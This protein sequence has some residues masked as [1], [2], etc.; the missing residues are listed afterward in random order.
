MSIARDMT[1]SDGKPVRSATYSAEFL[2]AN[3]DLRVAPFTG[4]V[5]LPPTLAPVR[6]LPSDDRASTLELKRCHSAVRTMPSA[7]AL[8]SA[9]A[10]V[11][12]TMPLR[13]AVPMPLVTGLTMFLLMMFLLSLLGLV[14]FRGGMA[15]ESLSLTPPIL[16]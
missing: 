9:S 12:V 1:D 2:S 3:A 6:Y 10:D 15:R 4:P 8:T 7:V 16:A 5:S 13:T 14:P 11:R